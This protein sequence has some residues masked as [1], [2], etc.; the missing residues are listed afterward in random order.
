M[1]VLRKAPS[2]RASIPAIVV[3]AGEQ[4][5]AQRSLGLLPDCFT[6]S[7]LPSMVPRASFKATS[8]VRPAFTP[9]RVRPSMNSKTYAGALPESPVT[10]S[11]RDS[12]TRQVTPMLPK[13]SSAIL[14]VA[15][16]TPSVARPTEPLPTVSGKFGITR[17]TWFFSPRTSRRL[18]R[19]TPAMML[20]NVFSLLSVAAAAFHSAATSLKICGFTQRKVTLAFSIPSAK[21]ATRTQPRA[22]TASAALSLG[23][24]KKMFLA[25]VPAFKRPRRMA[26]PMLPV[27]AKKIV[28]FIFC[29]LF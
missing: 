18:L 14:R 27:P 4:T 12:A 29:P 10:A 9:P 21:L 24:K 7:T 23:S 8:R 11:M 26:P 2:S 25:S 1:S 22:L 5:M 13:I 20:M 28:V 19:T 17:S 15:S 6:S 16:E 3:P